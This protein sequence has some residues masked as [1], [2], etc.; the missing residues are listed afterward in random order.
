MMILKK[1]PGIKEDPE[2]KQITIHNIAMEME[3]YFLF[4]SYRNFA[5]PRL[6]RNNF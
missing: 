3:P 6:C 5:T 2:V 1:D 4:N